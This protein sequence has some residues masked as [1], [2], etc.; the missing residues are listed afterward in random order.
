MS[1]GGQW[2]E[3]VSGLAA[4]LAQL[5]TAE[6]AHHRDEVDLRRGRRHFRTEQLWLHF[7][8]Q[9]LIPQTRP[10]PETRLRLCAGG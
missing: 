1:S 6:S 2:T 9:D 4:K 8:E 5:D 3:G 7:L 10:P